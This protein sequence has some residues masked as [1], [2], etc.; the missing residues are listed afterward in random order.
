MCRALRVSAS[1]YYDWLDRPPSP[2]AERHVKIQAVVQQV[3]AES[4][5]IYGSVKIAKQLRERP[6]LESACRNTVAQAMRELGLKSRIAK[7]FTPTTTHFDPTKQPAPNQ[8]AQDFTAAAPNRKWVTD[9]TYLATAEGWIYLAVVL[10]L[11]SRKVVGWALS[12]SL[13]TELVSEALR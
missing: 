5:G 2:R 9:I 8:L 13:A 12:N 6:D 10:D 3:H 1:G 11:F 7:A 4:H